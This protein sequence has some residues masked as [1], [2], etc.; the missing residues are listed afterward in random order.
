MSKSV[1][2]CVSPRRAF[3]KAEGRERPQES[4][5]S[6]F[7]RALVR[8]GARTG[9]AELRKADD[10]SS[11]RCG[12]R[13]RARSTRSRR[14]LYSGSRY[15]ALSPPAFEQCPRFRGCAPT[16]P[17]RHRPEGGRNHVDQ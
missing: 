4:E 15:I 6:E 11:I 1:T 12:D 10:Q 8:A 5:S 3:V 17:L 14:I 13:L 2:V 9:P 16:G 7:E